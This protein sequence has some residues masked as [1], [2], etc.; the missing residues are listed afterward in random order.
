MNIY[1]THSQKWGTPVHRRH[2]PKH[3]RSASRWPPFIKQSST[4]NLGCPPE[5]AKPQ[6]SICR[7]KKGGEKKKNIP[8]PSRRCACP[9]PGPRRSG[10]APQRGFAR[11]VKRNPRRTAVSSLELHLSGVHFGY[12]FLPHGPCSRASGAVSNPNQQPDGSPEP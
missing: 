1:I 11:W 4:R 12:A 5:R 8:A 3:L 6:R 9:G 7:K 2:A 10:T